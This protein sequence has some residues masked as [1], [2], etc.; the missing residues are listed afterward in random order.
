MPTASPYYT[1]NHAQFEVIKM[2]RVRLPLTSVE[3]SLSI[4]GVFGVPEEWK[5]TDEANPGLFTYELRFMA[6]ETA[7]AKVHP[8]QLTAKE[9]REQEEKGKKGGK[10]DSKDPAE[11]E[12]LRKQ[13]E[14]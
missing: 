1:G 2:E 8:R 3:A 9:Q 14:E 10:K 6:F 5:T 13:E 11:E 12:Q 7:G 4:E